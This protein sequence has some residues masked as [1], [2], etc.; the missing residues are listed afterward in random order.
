MAF[1]KLISHTLGV[2]SLMRLQDRICP[3]FLRN[4]YLKEKKGN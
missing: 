4:T 2:M 1:Q 3:Q